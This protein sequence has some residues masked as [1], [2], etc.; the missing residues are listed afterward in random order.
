M[1]RR[2]GWDGVTARTGNPVAVVVSDTSGC[3]WAGGGRQHCYRYRG[4]FSTWS[5][6]G[7]RDH[8]GLELQATI[9]AVADEVAVAS[10]LVS[11][12]LNRSRVIGVLCMNPAKERLE[13]RHPGPEER[14]SGPR[15][16]PLPVRSAG[17]TTHAMRGG[18]PPPMHLTRRAGRAETRLSWTLGERYLYNVKRRIRAY[19]EPCAT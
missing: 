5:Y 18:A 11:E 13:K 15:Q 9:Q 10:G 1:H 2:T 14:S 3:P 16:A 12:K 19:I 17:P 8:H 6:V 4:I 7:A